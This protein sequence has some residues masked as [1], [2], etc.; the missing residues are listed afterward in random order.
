MQTSN[1]EEW[2]VSTNP[3][4][5]NADLR[6]TLSFAVAAALLRLAQRRTALFSFPQAACTSI[7]GARCR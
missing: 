3:K 7:V 6:A 1:L 5:M 4:S 2:F